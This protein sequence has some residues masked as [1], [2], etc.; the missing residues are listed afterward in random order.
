MK[1]IGFSAIQSYTNID[2]RKLSNDYWRLK[3]NDKPAAIVEFDS[4]PEGKR[5]AYLAT[6]EDADEIIGKEDVFNRFFK[7]KAIKE[8]FYIGKEPNLFQRWMEAG[9]VRDILHLVSGKASITPEI[10]LID[11]FYVSITHTEMSGKR[12]KPRKYQALYPKLT[13]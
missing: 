6:E 4:I 8:Q 9:F 10:E 12:E 5:F 2:L 3:D 1:A 11:P 13:I 7:P